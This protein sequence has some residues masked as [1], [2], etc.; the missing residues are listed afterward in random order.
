MLSGHFL[1]A[2][3]TK[4]TKVHEGDPWN[5]GLRDTSCPSWFMHF[6]RRIVKLTDSVAFYSSDSANLV[7]EAGGK[8]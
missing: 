1:K 8:L 2:L 5:Y 6:V 7:T 4:G 3:T